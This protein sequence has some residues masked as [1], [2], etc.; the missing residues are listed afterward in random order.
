MTI[1]EQVT[2]WASIATC[3]GVMATMWGARHQARKTW[4]L[5]SAQVVTTLVEKFNSHEWGEIR[6]KQ[7]I[8]L[9]LKSD[10]DPERIL[11]GNYG[12]G[13]LGFYPPR[14]SAR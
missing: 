2:I 7:F 4:L 10:S 1:T 8:K 12:Y 13:V 14:H 9:L 11:I 5:N 3:L 6:R